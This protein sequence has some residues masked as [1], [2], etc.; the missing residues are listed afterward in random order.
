MDG[1]RCVV[2]CARVA[3]QIEKWH[4]PVV[5]M[6]KAECY[7]L[8]LTVAKAVESRVT[9]YGVA[10]GQEG[11]ELRALTDKPILVTT[12]MWTVYE[13]VANA[14]TP[15][16]QSPNDIRRLGEVRTPLAVHIK[17]NTGMNRF[18][19][20]SVAEL[21][22]VL[23]AIDAH[24][25]LY[26]SGACTHYASAHTYGEQNE[27]LAPLMSLLPR[28][29][30]VHTQASSTAEEKGFDMLRLGLCAYRDCVRLETSVVAVRRVMAGERVG[31]DGVYRAEKDVFIVVMAGGYADG[32]AKA[33]RGHLVN[34]RGRLFPIVAVCMDVC[35]VA[36]DRPP[37]VGEKVIVLGEG[38]N[39]TGLSLYEMYTGLHGR[40]AFAYIGAE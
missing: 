11:A 12:P 17:L 25:Y 3:R 5:L 31:Y 24:P 7:G 9:G 36:C 20:S 2:D 18:G 23:R 6:A 39:P 8:G 35:M 19:L 13:I 15:C 1:L 29:V 4:K 34:I 37:E 22:E 32:L 38:P 21:R 16:V 14:L 40:C 28:G 33:L 30:C 27:R 10:Y 26:V